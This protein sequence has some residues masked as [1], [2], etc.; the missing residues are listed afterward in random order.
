MGAGVDG[1]YGLWVDE[2]FE[3]GITGK[4]E[5]FENGVLCDDRLNEGEEGEG[6]QEKFEPMVVEVWAVG[7]D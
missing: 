5:T 7:M 3:K 6:V 4:C 1:H 2:A